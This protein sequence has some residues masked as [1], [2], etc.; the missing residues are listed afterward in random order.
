MPI[1]RDRVNR[2]R[3]YRFIDRWIAFIWT[4]MEVTIPQGV[5]GDVDKYSI[6]RGELEVIIYVPM[7]SPITIRRKGRIIISPCFTFSKKFG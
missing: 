1:K 3:L 6:N 5:L 4:K 2:N 7:L